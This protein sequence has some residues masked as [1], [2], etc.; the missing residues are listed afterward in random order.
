MPPPLP[1][2]G[3]WNTK[4]QRHEITLFLNGQSPVEA[5]GSQVLRNVQHCDIVSASHDGCGGG[6]KSATMKAKM[7]RMPAIA[8]QAAE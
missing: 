2:G 5:D 6:M 4:G 1:R 8:P 7:K 3:E